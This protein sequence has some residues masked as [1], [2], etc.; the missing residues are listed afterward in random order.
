MGQAIGHIGHA[1]EP[2]H[3]HDD[4]GFNIHPVFGF[5]LLGIAIVIVWVIAGYA[6]YMMTQPV[7]PF[8]Y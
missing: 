6:G 8:T 7:K 3:R 4:E 1:V 5:L 2:V